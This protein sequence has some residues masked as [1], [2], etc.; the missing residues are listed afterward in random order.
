MAPVVIQQI[1]EPP[2]LRD[3]VYGPYAKVIVGM[4][5][6]RRK[7]IPEDIG[8]SGYCNETVG[9]HYDIHPGIAIAHKYSLND[10]V[11][12]LAERRDSALLT[13]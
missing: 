1:V 4:R 8:D 5:K 10:S 6:M 2:E 13:V 12:T 9:P 7:Q 11:R 3:D